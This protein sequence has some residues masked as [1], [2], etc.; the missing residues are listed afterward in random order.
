[1]A[2]VIFNPSIQ[3]IWGRMGGLVYRRSHTGEA[4]LAVAPNMSRVKWSQA[5]K[6]HRQRFK[7]AVAYARAA[8]ARPEVRAIYERMAAENHKRPFDMAV[9]DYFKG[10]DLLAKN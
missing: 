10:R 3:R 8:M 6:E 2:K 5:Q 1:M 4:Q 9:S 7:Q